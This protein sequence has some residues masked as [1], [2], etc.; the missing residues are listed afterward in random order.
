MIW[1]HSGG[2]AVGWKSQ[3][4]GPGGLF[5]R[6][7][8]DGS[9]EILY[10]AMNYRL[11][12]L[13]WLAGPGVLRGIGSGN[14]GLFDQRLAMLWVKENIWRFGGDPDE[15]TVFGE[16]AGGASILHHITANGGLGPAPPFKRAIL[17]SAAFFPQPEPTQQYEGYKRLL[18]ETGTGSLTELRKLEPED[19]IEANSKVIRRS[20]YGQFTFGPVIDGF[21]VPTLPGVSLLAGQYH[22]G[23][24]LMLAYNELEGLLF[25]PPYIQTNESFHQYLQSV[26]PAAPGSA[27][28]RI[29]EFY[30]PLEEG[31]RGGEPAARINRLAQALGDA[32]VNCN[33]YYLHHATTVFEPSKIHRGYFFAPLGAIHSLDVQYTYFPEAQPDK[34]KTLPSSTKALQRYLTNFAKTGDPNDDLKPN[35]PSF[36]QYEAGKQVIKFGPLSIFAA[37]DPINVERCEWWQLAEYY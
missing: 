14:V 18:N 20:N 32:A 3:S 24:E 30:P 31:I 29:E 13:G 4:G 34:P 16:S 23:I 26:L 28:T 37:E 33:T 19:L 27:L 6:S 9:D 11:G 7:R 5:E 8:L 2:F 35:L 12:A 22:R 21:Y 10:V 36:P 1:I 15:V 25:T 17:Q